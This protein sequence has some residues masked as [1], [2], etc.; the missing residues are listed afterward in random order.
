MNLKMDSD[1]I[2][3][4]HKELSAL[5]RA[6]SGYLQE[7]PRA[8]YLWPFFI[9]R[10]LDKLGK[11]KQG[12]FRYATPSQHNFVMSDIMVKKA[13]GSIVCREMAG[14]SRQ[15]RR[16]DRAIHQRLSG[17]Y[18]EVQTCQAKDRAVDADILRRIR[19]LEKSRSFLQNR[20]Q[21]RKLRFQGELSEAFIAIFESETASLSP[22][23][24]LRDYETLLF[25]LTDAVRSND[26]NAI[27]AGAQALAEKLQV[28][29]ELFS[30][31]LAGRRIGNHEL[32]L[33]GKFIKALE[34]SKQY[35][36]A[37]AALKEFSR[38]RKGKL[39]VA[40]LREVKGTRISDAFV[41]SKQAQCF[42]YLVKGQRLFFAAM[43]AF[44][45]SL[46]VYGVDSIPY[47]PAVTLFWMVVCFGV[48]YYISW[49]PSH[50]ISLF[51]MSVF[52]DIPGHKK[53]R[54]VVSYIHT[55]YSEKDPLK[56]D[57]VI[58]KKSENDAD[59][60]IARFYF[61]K[62]IQALAP[63]LETFGKKLLLVFHLWSDTKED[64]IIDYE[65]KMMQGL[66]GEFPQE[67]LIFCY[68]NRS[69]SE[70]FDN[71]KFGMAKAGGFAGKVGCIGNFLHF[72]NTGETKPR[73][74]IDEGFEA[75]QNRNVPLFCHF[76]SSD[77]VRAFGIQQGK[78][79]LDQE[80][81]LRKI[82][83]GEDV[84]I[85]PE[86]ISEYCFM[87]DDKNEL[88][89]GEL[90]KAIAIMAHPENS[91][92]VI[93][94]PHITITPPFHEG[95]AK[96]STFW[97]I[98]KGERDI[99]NEINTKIVSGL[100]G[101]ER[102]FFGKGF[103]RTKLYYERVFKNETLSPTKL[104]S[105]DWQESIFSR[106]CEGFF[107]A[108]RFIVK[109]ILERP[110]TAVLRV[111][112]P[113]A[114]S[115][116]KIEKE[117][118]GSVAV[119]HLDLFSGVYRFSRTFRHLEG[120][121][122]DETVKYVAN[123]YGNA[124]FVG[125]RDQLH[126]V[127]HII[128]DERWLIG[129][130][131]ALR[132]LIAYWKILTPYH[133]WHFSW[134]M[135][136][137][138][139]DVGLFVFIM[140][141]CLLWIFQFFFVLPTSSSAYYVTLVLAFFGIIVVHRFIDPMR[142]FVRR[143]HAE[144]RAVRPLAFTV[145]F[146]NQFFRS[147]M[148]TL[149]TTMSA[150]QLT[151]IKPLLTHLVYRAEKYN[152]V[153]EWKTSSTLSLMELEEKI[154]PQEFKDIK[155]DEAQKAGLFI[156]GIAAT[157]V[158]TGIAP[159]AVLGIFGILPWA[160]SLMFG[161]YVIQAMGR[162]RDYRD[163]PVP[164]KQKVKSACIGLGVFLLALSAIGAVRNIPT[165][166]KPEIVKLLL[167]ESRDRYSYSD[168]ENRLLEKMRTDLEKI[169]FYIPEK[170]VKSKLTPLLKTREGKAEQLFEIEPLLERLTNAIPT[171]KPQKREVIAP[172]IKALPAP[173][174]APEISDPEAFQDFFKVAHKM[175]NQR[176]L[177]SVL[178]AGGKFFL[179][180][181]FFPAAIAILAIDRVEGLGMILKYFR[182]YPW[183][184]LK[185]PLAAQFWF[186]A[187]K[188]SGLSMK[189]I[190]KVFLWEETKKY[191][192][193]DFAH[194]RSVWKRYEYLQRGVLSLYYGGLEVNEENLRKFFTEY[195]RMEEFH[196]R[197]PYVPLKPFRPI[198]E[199]V[200]LLFKILGTGIFYVPIFDTAFLLDIPFGTVLS[201]VET[202]V[203]PY[204]GKLEYL[205]TMAMKNNISVDEV[206]NRI[207]FDYINYAWKKTKIPGEMYK[208]NKERY[209]E[210]F[211][212]KG[213][214]KVACEKSNIKLICLISDY[215][216]ASEIWNALDKGAHPT[217]AQLLA[218][219]NQ[220]HKDLKKIWKTLG[221][222]YP[223]LRD[224]FKAKGIGENLAARYYV[225]REK[226]G[227]GIDQFVD[228]L[229]PQLEEVRKLKEED[230]QIDENIIHEIMFQNEIRQNQ[231]YDDPRL[232]E[233]EHR[234]AI[235]SLEKKV[236]KQSDAGKQMTG[237]LWLSALIAD[238]K[239]NDIAA[240]PQELVDKF[241]EI[242]RKGNSIGYTSK[243]W[244]DKSG[245]LTLI[246]YKARF[247]DV[248]SLFKYFKKEFDYSNAWH[249]EKM[250]LPE[251]F[252]DGAASSAFRDMGYTP[253]EVK[254]LVAETPE[255]LKADIAYEFLAEL[256]L[257]AQYNG[258]QVKPRELA[259]EFMVFYRAGLASP[260][261]RIPWWSVGGY[262]VLEYYKNKERRGW[263]DM[264]DYFSF[265]AKTFA[266]INRWLTEDLA[267][268][269]GFEYENA[270]RLQVIK[271]KLPSDP[272]VSAEENKGVLQVI[273]D[274]VQNE[275]GLIKRYNAYMTLA[276]IKE[277][278]QLDFGRELDDAGVLKLAQT[279]MIFWKE[280]P[281]RYPQLPFFVPGI[282]EKLAIDSFAFSDPHEI[283]KTAHLAEINAFWDTP[284]PSSI[285]DALRN[286]IE[287]R[288]GI[289]IAD[290][291]G[292]HYAALQTAIGILNGLGVELSSPH[293]VQILQIRRLIKSVASRYPDLDL[294][295]EGSSEWIAVFAL[296][297]G[298]PF[299]ELEEKYLKPMQ[300]L[301]KPAENAYTPYEL[302]L[303]V[304]RV[305]SINQR[306]MALITETYGLKD[307]GYI[308]EPKTASRDV[309]LNTIW[310]HLQRSY[311]IGA[312][313]GD[314]RDFFK[315][316]GAVKR[317]NMEELVQIRDIE[318]L[319]EW[320]GKMD[321]ISYQLLP[322]YKNPKALTRVKSGDDF[323]YRFLANYQLVREDKIISAELRETT[324]AEKDVSESLRF[325]WPLWMSMGDVSASVMQ[326]ITSKMDAAGQMYREILGIEPEADSAVKFNEAVNLHLLGK[327]GKFLVNQRT[328]Y[329]RSQTSWWTNYMVKIAYKRLF[330][331]HLEESTRKGRRVL[332]N[333]QTWYSRVKLRDPHRIVLQEM[334]QGLANH[335]SVKRIGLFRP[336]FSGKDEYHKRLA[337]FRDYIRHLDD[338]IVA[339]KEEKRY[340]ANLEKIRAE[341][342]KDLIRLEN[343]PEELSLM[344]V[345]AERLLGICQKRHS[346]DS[347]FVTA[348]IFSGLFI[349]YLL[350]RLVF[351]ARKAALGVHRAQPA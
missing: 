296:K 256:F 339:L 216:M 193:C 73:L 151:I 24:D 283:E 45:P 328:L 70:W 52:A 34:N 299:P 252:V 136:R 14:S 330:G 137:I 122:M 27:K 320:Q 35:P 263:K 268:P 57:Y 124:V 195:A 243:P 116:I 218:I 111:E 108:K 315:I 164:F 225:I 171:L 340:T 31:S 262:L 224:G 168:S 49:V 76:W 160:G 192:D 194:Q 234:D 236:E 4:Y 208:V 300:E 68:A 294:S 241:M 304:E 205:I 343:A 143:A 190:A 97:K 117:E 266:Q 8:G 221:K 12:K 210:D 138:L 348:L 271:R 258:I 226:Y 26:Q 235:A 307:K 269:P 311:D 159:F 82:L 206:M 140:L 96:E 341:V 1:N 345:E 89:P 231:L 228:Y 10:F 203:T 93:G 279:L 9:T 44:V 72:M 115:F 204:G 40:Q 39:F 318:H 248:D 20:I 332:K 85:D 77:L 5:S 41:K 148:L 80:G 239:N 114:T 11:L 102:A 257:T 301:Y 163:I 278:Y 61:R 142:Y 286:E 207:G 212:R 324:A 280:L 351:F 53:V 321:S 144:G 308:S 69:K 157:Y 277:D 223:A 174:E 127:T 132:T 32:N 90:E 162:V 158:L 87:M 17:L 147:V 99:E 152:K 199:S 213:V 198:P 6:L 317:S 288:T 21:E 177:L 104:R 135:G 211:R 145:E 47:L 270:F 121:D 297:K 2:K 113:D 281:A 125:E 265:Y 18:D 186:E 178:L 202:I 98:M 173:L 38:Y 310:Y 312:D 181:E 253:E 119:S 154:T 42:E 131:Q 165:E 16:K 220:L 349:Y 67:N 292:L 100:Y 30:Q 305:R 7:L 264:N 285:E 219:S 126:F 101:K 46:L 189:R 229:A 284:I 146:V 129:D 255:K 326:R 289:W 43:V 254:M 182:K 242:Y 183:F 176:F 322:I 261:D 130:F 86:K 347:T 105:H 232:L 48:T 15:Y 344:A 79:R 63:T 56:I 291:K 33:L 217:N 337:R 156:T 92:I 95:K 172:P 175:G 64:K 50:K 227:W 54:D 134:A 233:F 222:K 28:P 331:E 65:I 88:Y 62:S 298:I 259:S 313:P 78:E 249:A 141:M 3:K 319:E 120:L 123:F 350:T 110:G 55:R 166:N 323:L 36:D 51:L 209:L 306:D 103:I 329:Q 179:S 316:L 66:H 214:E 106:N 187:S 334:M 250:P 25:R 215:R 139:L 185:D 274:N 245:Y 13:I 150:L 335:G 109:K 23:K 200:M 83:G 84:A 58:A 149:E 246:Y 282:V 333:M 169:E 293:I 342:Q 118:D 107:G 237:Y 170:V 191:W 180:M 153:P 309:L 74:F 295:R 188:L 184:T 260:Y 196:K 155:I 240:T 251:G 201:I 325:L 75:T 336:V 91:H 276:R 133:Q 59:A 287:A 302:E 290:R 230:F 22:V 19:N 37:V 238:A 247:Q 303:A 128:R 273:E 81:I 94:Q 29:G 272:R 71:T 338:E 275:T 197:Y 244:W 267:L 60:E 161:R 346:I 327:Y 167:P 112:L 314:L